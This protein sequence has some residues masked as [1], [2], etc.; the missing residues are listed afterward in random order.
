MLAGAAPARAILTRGNVVYFDRNSAEVPPRGITTIEANLRL[1]RERGPGVTFHIGAMSEASEA[2]PRSLAWQ[3]ATIV[4]R[5][6]VQGG[7]PADSCSMSI[8]VLDMPSTV[9]ESD[10]WS[11]RVADIDVFGL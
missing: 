7:V 9:D 4:M 1:F 11:A 8:V 6:L 5:L 2:D 3:R 10:R